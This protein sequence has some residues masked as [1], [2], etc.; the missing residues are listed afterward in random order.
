MASF[1]SSYIPT[2]GAAATR[3]A[4]AASMT[5]TNF[6]EWYRQDEG[7]FVVTAS[8]SAIDMAAIHEHYL[9]AVSSG[10]AANYIALRGFSGT[11]VSAGNLLVD[12]LVVASSVVQA[13]TTE[14]TLLP[15]SVFT[16][17]VAFKTNDVASSVNAST[18]STDSSVVIPTVS[19]LYVGGYPS[20][21]A[22]NAHIRRIAFI[23][24]RIAN[25]ELQAIT[26]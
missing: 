12:A 14:V 17:A 1:A 21:W 4:D 2:A 9:V 15:G 13:D 3:A 22:K 23:P 16:A 25:A 10:S 26:A 18:P 7:T 6:S 24:K 19:T 11:G 8:V 5:G 20:G